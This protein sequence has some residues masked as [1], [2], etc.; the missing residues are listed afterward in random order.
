MHDRL[1]RRVHSREE[2]LGSESSSVAKGRQ[3]RGKPI[4]EHMRSDWSGERARAAP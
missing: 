1:W 4:A 3:R 2:R